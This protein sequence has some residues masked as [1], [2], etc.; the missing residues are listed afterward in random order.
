MQSWRYAMTEIKYKIAKYCA[1]IIA[2]IAIT[3]YIL[4]HPSSWIYARSSVKK[5]GVLSRAAAQNG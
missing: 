1:K 2:Q 3:P 5:F 4:F